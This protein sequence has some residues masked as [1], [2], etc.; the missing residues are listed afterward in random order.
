MAFLSPKV[1]IPF[2]GGYLL[3]TFQVYGGQVHIN[4]LGYI[5]VFGLA[6]AFFLIASCIVWLIK[7]KS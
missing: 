7:E 2:L 5:V 3:D 4:F 6:A 1:F